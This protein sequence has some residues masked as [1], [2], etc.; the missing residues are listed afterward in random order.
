MI[1]IN[2]I[3][4]RYQARKLKLRSLRPWL[5]ILASALVLVFALQHYARV[6]ARMRSVEGDL[7]TVQGALSDYQPLIEE[8][9]ALISQLD[10]AK[11][12]I[13]EIE[14]AYQAIDIQNVIWSE[15][16]DFAVQTAPPDVEFTFVD[17]SAGVV[18]ISGVAE[19]YLSPITFA[20]DLAAS[21]RFEDVLIESIVKVEPALEVVAEE[22]E[23]AEEPTVIALPEPVYE[24]EITLVLFE[25]SETP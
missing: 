2:L 13:A 10:G 11:L 12:Q 3:P 23:D 4:S 14:D 16:L 5:F 25:A 24:F 1:D 21:G 9:D 20:D 22:G 18:V 17:Q 15:I 7:A 8:R 6:H 19:R